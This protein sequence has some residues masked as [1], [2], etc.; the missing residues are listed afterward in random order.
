MDL[1][2]KDKNILI[3]G[4]AKGIGRGIALAAAQEGANVA[5]H[6]HHSAEQAQTTAKEIEG[7][8]VKVVLTQGDL[9]VISDVQRMKQEVD[10]AF[11]R[12]DGVVNN[13]GWAQLKSF[14]KY[15]PE[16]WKQEI[17]ICLYGVLHIAHTF[18][19]D[20]M[21][22]NSGKFIN[23]IGDS[24]RTG[25]RNLILSAAAR[26]GTVSFMKSLAQETG[27][28]N[29]QCNTVSLGLVDQGYLSFDQETLEK[30]KKQYPLKRIGTI[31]DVS[32]TVLFLLSKSSD[33]VTGQVISVNGGYSMIG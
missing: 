6:Y 32:G 3:T 8:G 5:L 7:Y 2:L 19:P 9:A 28:S 26:A 11:G 33:W 10:A 13:A 16:E 25:D 21:N 31:D 15:K 30:I 29:I 20:M 1:G 14:F 24:A 4:A 22:A 12:L 18:L 17:D 27:R 23:I